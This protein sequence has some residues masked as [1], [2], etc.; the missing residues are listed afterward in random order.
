MS[1]ILNNQNYRT[2]KML[3]AY[4]KIIENQTK[5]EIKRLTKKDYQNLVGLISI[6]EDENT[7]L[8]DMNA[9]L[10]AFIDQKHLSEEWTKL[11]S[12]ENNAKSE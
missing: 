3:P 2:S 5:G 7:Q 8:R 12:G 1:D 10:I 4:Q 11:I 9:K 6:L